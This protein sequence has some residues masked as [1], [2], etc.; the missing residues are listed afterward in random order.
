MANNEDSAGKAA[1]LDGEVD[2]SI[3]GLRTGKGLGKQSGGRENGTPEHPH[4]FNMIPSWL[5]SLR[6][7][8]IVA[9]LQRLL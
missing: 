7:E 9:E 8:T 3:E 5:K 6:W 4:T 1:L 2:G